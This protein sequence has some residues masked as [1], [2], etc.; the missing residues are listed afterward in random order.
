MLKS[1]KIGSR[2]S[3]VKN[4][5]DIFVESVLT[6]R[7]EKKLRE[8]RH[9]NI[10]EYPE[11]SRSRSQRDLHVGESSKQEVSSALPALVRKYELRSLT[12]DSKNLKKNQ[13]I[14]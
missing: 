12:C 11:N 4:D 2:T 9:L 10:D 14:K 6:A 13:V 1:H 8:G 7:R 5:A 3:H